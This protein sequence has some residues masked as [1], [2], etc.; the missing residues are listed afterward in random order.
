MAAWGDNTLIASAES[1]KRSS[2]IRA[3]PAALLLSTTCR[4]SPVEA[5]HTRSVLSHDPDTTR[6]SASATSDLTRSVCPSSVRSHSP[7]AAFHTRSVLS[8]DP[9]PV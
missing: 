8:P 6:P 2:D 3:A 5:F 4:H 7:V 9:D 1:P